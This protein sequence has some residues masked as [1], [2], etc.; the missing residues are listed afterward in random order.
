MLM[1]LIDGFDSFE[2]MY[3]IYSVTFIWLTPII[4][5]LFPILFT[6]NQLFLSKPKLFLFP[7]FTISL[8]LLVALASKL[9][10]LICIMILGAPF[11][12][13]AGIVGL[14]LGAFIRRREIDKRVYSIF[15]LPLLLNPIENLFPDSKSNFQVKSSIIIN[16]SATA[17][18][19]NLLEVP[20]ISEKEY[21][22]GAFQSLGI[23]RPIKSEVYSDGKDLYRIGTFTDGLK[24]YEEITELKKN[25]FVS[26]KIDLKKSQLRDTPTDQHI[27]KSK[28]FGF[29]YISYHLTEINSNQT[30]VTLSCD[31]SLHSKMNFYANIWAR[32]IIQDFEERLLAAIK[33]KLEKKTF[34]S[35]QN[36]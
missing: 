1:R 12:I 25:E 21:S 35:L 32:A 29:N 6:S 24:L 5:G 19:P 34:T 10:D 8:F 31:Y 7:I 15:L 26:F 4:I 22:S 23:P 16:Q 3:S 36:S 18:F 33:L 28:N 9:E 20:E 11:L 14:L 17:I 2:D 30:C 27:L 13:V